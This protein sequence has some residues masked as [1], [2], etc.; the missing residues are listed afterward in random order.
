MNKKYSSIRSVLNFRFHW[1]SE[2]YSLGKCYRDIL[3]LPSFLPLLFTSDHGVNLGSA[4]DSGILELNEDCFPHLTWSSKVQKL[5]E[6]LSSPKF[7]GFPHP[8]VAYRRKMG[9]EPSERNL[10]NE[11]IYFPIHSSGGSKP[12]GFDDTDGIQFLKENFSSDVKVRVC[13]THGDINSSRSNL[14]KEQGYEI[15]T[16]GNPWDSSFVDNFYSLIK[17]CKLLIS[18]GFGSQV[19]YAVEFGIPVY[20][21][22]RISIEVDEITGEVRRNIFENYPEVES[23]VHYAE[24]LFGKLNF[25]ISTDQLEFIHDLLGFQFI[26][27]QRKAIRTLR[28]RNVALLPYWFFKYLMIRNFMALV[29]AIWKSPHVE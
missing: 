27:Q 25:G 1:S 18:E 28:F 15:V 12:Y 9:L 14:F 6:K 20:V 16:V 21:V 29:R 10:R 23:R 8:W 22:P 7:L 11:V 4:F 19:A 24:Q 3:G 17:D 5:E 26:A 2:I 13:F